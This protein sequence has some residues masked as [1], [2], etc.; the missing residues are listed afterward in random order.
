MNVEH[1]QYELVT[2]GSH[3]S[4]IHHFLQCARMARR[5]ETMSIDWHA[6]ITRYEETTKRLVCDVAEAVGQRFVDA[7]SAQQ[8]YLAL[9]AG[10]ESIN[11]LCGEIEAAGTDN[12]LIDK[13][14][15]TRGLWVAMTEYVGVRIGQM[16]KATE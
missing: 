12:K 2:I 15:R 1:L 4:A 9:Q 16:P 14:K 8:L 6:A 13:C 3:T 11:T 10:L 5:C 7:N